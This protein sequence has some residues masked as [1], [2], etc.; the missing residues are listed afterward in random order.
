M[1][2]PN[3]RGVTIE[4]KPGG[5]WGLLIE[6]FMLSGRTQRMARAKHILRNL[7]LNGWCCEW[8]GGPVPEFRRADANSAVKGA[9]SARRGPGAPYDYPKVTREPQGLCKGQSCGGHSRM[10]VRAG[11]NL[12]IHHGSEP[13]GRTARE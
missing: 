12:W 11:R 4:E 6:T 10:R 7:R 8:C 2:A 3:P 13:Q 5:G 9:E 1:P